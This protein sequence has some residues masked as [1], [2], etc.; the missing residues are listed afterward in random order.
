MRRKRQESIMEKEVSAPKEVQKP[1]E[2]A[3]SDDV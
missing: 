1:H 2:V 3:E